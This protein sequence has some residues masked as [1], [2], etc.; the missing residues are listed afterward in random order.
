MKMN[1]EEALMRVGE[2]KAFI[3]EGDK[4]E[5]MVTMDKIQDLL[6]LGEKR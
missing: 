5:A 4:V 2:L 6:A 3:E 1:K